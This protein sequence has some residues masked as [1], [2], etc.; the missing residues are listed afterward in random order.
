MA[1]RKVLL[2]ALMALAPH[3]RAIIVAGAQAVY[4]RTGS[5]DLAVAPFTTDG[6]LALDPEFLLGDPRLETAMRDAGFHLSQSDGHDEPGVWLSR[7]TVDGRTFDIP[8]DLIVPAAV[9]PPGSRRSA[10]FPPHEKRAVRRAVGL[11]AALVDHDPM[12]ITGLDPTD[13]RTVTTEIAGV[14]ALLVAK[15]HKIHDRVAE[16]GRR[17][18]LDKDAGDIFRLMQTSDVVAIR[19]TLSELLAHPMAGDVTATGLRHLLD[20][21]SRPASKGTLMAIDSFR[22]AVPADRVVSITNSF[23]ASLS[24][25]L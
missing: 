7:T 9:A 21:F 22:S 8:V 13:D 25:L 20:L 17:R 1:A 6:D 5:A 10:H 4:L 12:I 2:D 14:A 16:P 11:E 19:Q 24:S 15:A 3:G 23:A 18:I